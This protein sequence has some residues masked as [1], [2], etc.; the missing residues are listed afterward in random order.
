LTL[1][2]RKGDSSTWDLTA[3]LNA[4]DGLAGRAQR[5]LWLARLM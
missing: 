4:A 3:L 1:F 2:S 5:H